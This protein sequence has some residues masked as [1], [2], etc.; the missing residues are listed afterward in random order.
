MIVSAGI[1]AMLM[2]CPLPTIIDPEARGMKLPT[3]RKPNLREHKQ[4]KFLTKNLAE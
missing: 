2:P 1:A 3:E 4:H